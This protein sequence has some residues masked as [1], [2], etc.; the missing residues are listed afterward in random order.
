M[1]K[2]LK[3]LILALLVVL[4]GSRVASADDQQDTYTLQ[5]DDGAKSF[6]ISGPG[7]NEFLK[8][9][10]V[11]VI[12]DSDT[13]DSA[14]WMLQIDGAKYGIEDLA[15]QG[16]TVSVNGASPDPAVLRTN[17]IYEADVRSA[18]IMGFGGDGI[19]ALHVFDTLNTAIDQYRGLVKSRFVLT[20][21]AKPAVDYAATSDSGL[22]YR[23]F[24]IDS[25]KDA[26][27]GAQYFM[28]EFFELMKDDV[29]LQWRLS[30]L[31]AKYH[32][33][34]YDPQYWD[35][36]QQAWRDYLTNFANEAAHSGAMVLKTYI[37]MTPVVGQAASVI[38]GIHD[39]LMHS[40]TEGVLECIPLFP[41]IFKGLRTISLYQIAD[42]TSVASIAAS[43]VSST[44]QLKIVQQSRQVLSS[45]RGHYWLWHG[46]TRILSQ[47]NPTSGQLVNTRG[48]GFTYIRCIP[49]GKSL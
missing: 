9:S 20:P 19:A 29:F 17:G 28:Q 21:G 33:Q 11:R 48:V 6:I 12:N 37:C 47:R 49:L 31:Q 1:I 46:H 45:D 43:L 38:F 18:V 5:S 24:H 36:F 32:F 26:Y 2:S 30:F 40:Y 3:R 15:D 7:A 34:D 10:V 16:L 8:D 41:P 14:N 22:S 4:A 42:E 27:T 25:S 44:A 23:N 35:F 13:G 39:I